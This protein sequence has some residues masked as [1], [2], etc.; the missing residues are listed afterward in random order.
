MVQVSNLEE[1]WGRCNKAAELKFSPS[2]PYTR[3]SCLEECK[4]EEIKNICNCI[5]YYAKI[6]NL[7]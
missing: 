4:V 7:F 1:P 3:E 6:G 2:Y 5:P